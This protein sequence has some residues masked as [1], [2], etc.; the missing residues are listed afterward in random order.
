MTLFLRESVGVH[1]GHDPEP[2]IVLAHAIG[3]HFINGHA[4]PF[5]G[6]VLTDPVMVERAVGVE[7]FT[8][9]TTLVSIACNFHI[10]PPYYVSKSLQLLS[11]KRY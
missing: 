8:T 10:K 6:G 11:I 2:P 1:L 4:A 5:F 3:E 9:S 7:V